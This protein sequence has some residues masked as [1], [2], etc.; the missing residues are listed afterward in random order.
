M[1]TDPKTDRC[2]LRVGKARLDYAFTPAVGSGGTVEAFT[3]SGERVFL[4]ESPNIRGMIASIRAGDAKRPTNVTRVQASYAADEYDG[5]FVAMWLLGRRPVIPHRS[6]TYRTVVVERDANRQPLRQELRHRFGFSNGQLA[7]GLSR[8]ITTVYGV[9]P[10]A[11][12]A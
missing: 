10:E 9:T 1:E 3:R 5:I 11:I 6:H 8:L 2:S 12:P 7:T 4:A